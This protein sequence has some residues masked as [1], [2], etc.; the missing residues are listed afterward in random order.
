MSTV[1]LSVT[2]VLPGS[3]MMTSQ[4][5]EENPQENYDRNF[6]LLQVKK[7]DYKTKKS[8]F[9][10]EPL[11][12]KTRKCKDAT[13]VIKMYEEAYEYMTSVAC[14]EWYLPMGGINKWKKLSK[15]QRLEEHLNRLCKAMGGKSYT[16]AVYPD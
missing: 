1:K 6:M 12:F 11:E 15:E 7:Y 16:Y 4:E 8:Y 14:P 10:K 5:C 13:Q 2:I 3:V 9:K